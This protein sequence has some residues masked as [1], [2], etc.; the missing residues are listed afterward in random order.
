MKLKQ[1]VN[2]IQQTE[3]VVEVT[4]IVFPEHHKITN[5]YSLNRNSTHG[6]VC[7]ALGLIHS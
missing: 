2:N 4:N 5:N 7:R 1:Q 3:T 6:G